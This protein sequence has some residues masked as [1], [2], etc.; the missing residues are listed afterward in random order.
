[1]ASMGRGRVLA[2]LF[3]ALAA[4]RLEASQ[5]RTLDLEELTA[6]AGRIFSGRCVAVESVVHP[7]LSFAVTRVTFEVEQAVKGDLSSTVTIDLFGGGG[8]TLAETPRFVPGERA[9]L[10]LYPPSAL[11]LTSPVALGQGKFALVRDKQGREFAINA[12]GNRNLMSEVDETAA[13]PAA[14]LLDGVRQLLQLAA[15]AP[16]GGR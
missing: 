7:Q 11:G 14:A 8:L 6:R 13:L 16:G 4:G 15:P 3:L 5:V 2:G 12:F 10:F 1:M 9:I